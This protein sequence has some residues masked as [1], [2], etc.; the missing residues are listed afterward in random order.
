MYLIK[1]KN[2]S[3]WKVQHSRSHEIIPMPEE[4]QEFTLKA[5]QEVN[6]DI[7]ALDIVETSQ[8]YRILE[9]NDAPDINP[10]FLGIEDNTWDFASK[11]LINKM[12][13]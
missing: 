8:G 7:G 13:N 3:G 11:L 5:K 12:K 6:L 1:R 10:R 2:I 4:I 9:I